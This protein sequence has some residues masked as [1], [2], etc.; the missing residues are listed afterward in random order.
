MELSIYAVKWF[1][2]AVSYFGSLSVEYAT[3]V[4]RSFSSVVTG[5][6]NL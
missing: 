4:T 1:S 3:I 2:G 5:M 6:I